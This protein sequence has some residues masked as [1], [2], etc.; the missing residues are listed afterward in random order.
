MPRE[1][2]KL[3]PAVYLI[4]RR[5][6][7]VMLARRAGNLFGAGQY[8]LVAGH[9]D[10]GETATAAVVREAREEVDIDVDERDLRCV[11]VMHRDS[12]VGEWFDLFFTCERWRNEPRIAEPDLC[13]DLL[14]RPV[15]DLPANTLPWIRRV[16]ER[17]RRGEFF[18]AW[19]F[20]S[21][22]G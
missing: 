3:I 12:D 17:W 22:E 16:L 2:F 18:T 4:L 21:D 1:R 11:H 6:D 7:H 10:G 19:G 9:V 8:S 20:T 13:D 15:G 5:G 14:W